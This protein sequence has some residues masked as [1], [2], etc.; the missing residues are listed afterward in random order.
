MK[1]ISLIVDKIPIIKINKTEIIVMELDFIDF[2]QSPTCFLMEYHKS[3]KIVISVLFEDFLHQRPLRF[4][5]P[6]LDSY[7]MEVS[8]SNCNYLMD[9]WIFYC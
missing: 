4:T 9:F 8:V 2:K 3:L 6:V 7:S 5:V 1:G